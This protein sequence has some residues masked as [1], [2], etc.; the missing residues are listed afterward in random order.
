MSE[1]KLFEEARRNLYRQ[2]EEIGVD[3]IKQDLATGGHAYVGGSPARKLLAVQ[4][5]HMKEE[6]NKAKSAG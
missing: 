4:W 5:V 1:N 3:I 6:E 2:W